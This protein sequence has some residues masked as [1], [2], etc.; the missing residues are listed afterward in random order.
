[1]GNDRIFKG[2]GFIV[3]ASI[4]YSFVLKINQPD[5][6]TLIKS[7]EY[8]KTSCVLKEVNIPMGFFQND[9]NRLDCEGVI[10]N[11]SAKKYN[12]ATSVYLDSLQNKVHSG[13][14]Q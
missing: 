8:W 1:M 5:T 10:T 14:G 4:L 3:I 2:C 12:K 7:G 11:V 9:M 6:E 13:S